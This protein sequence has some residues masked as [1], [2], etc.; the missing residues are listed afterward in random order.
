MNFDT[1]GNYI[2]KINTGM[3]E[4]IMSGEEAFAR[5]FYDVE[6]Y[7][8]PV[9]HGMIHAIDAFAKGDKAA[10]ARHV[11][12]VAAEMRLVLGTYFDRLHNKM[13]ARSVW[14]SHVQGYYAWG[15]GNFNKETGEWENY[16]GLSGNQILLFQALD[17]FLGMDQYLAPRDRERN[18]PKRQRDLCDLMKKHCFR[19]ML[20][21]TSEDP[22]E[23]EIVRNMNDILKRLRVSFPL[24]AY[25][26]GT[27]T[28]ERLDVP[29][30]APNPC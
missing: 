15:A 21:E 9:Y 16:D 25:Y 4:A 27:E 19:S 23:I 10:C 26:T 29:C 30:C 13:I 22:H 3:P 1:Q 28:N 12:T 24:L 6:R 5:I 14:L 18:V 20:S 17:A 11:A 8:V 2:Y 7:G